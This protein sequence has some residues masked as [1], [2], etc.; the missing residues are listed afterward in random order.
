MIVPQSLAFAH[1]GY[2]DERSDKYLVIELNWRLKIK[3]PSHRFSQTVWAGGR[4]KWRR[5]IC[6]LGTCNSLHSQGLQTTWQSVRNAYEVKKDERTDGICLRFLTAAELTALAILQCFVTER[7]ERAL[8][9]CKPRDW[10]TAP[11]QVLS[12]HM[13][14]HNLSLMTEYQ[15]AISKRFTAFK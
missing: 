4:L 15:T 3:T 5:N 10:K 11:A 12:L 14:A 8:Q 6:S 7:L 13:R 2:G 1:K 9:G